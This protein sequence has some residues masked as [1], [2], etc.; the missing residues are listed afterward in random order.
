MGENAFENK[1]Y[2]RDNFISGGRENAIVI[3]IQF[4]VLHLKAYVTSTRKQILQYFIE[5]DKEE[6]EEE[7]VEEG[8]EEII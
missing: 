5:E 6:G 3:V 1:F 8:K 7:K 4:T 2:F